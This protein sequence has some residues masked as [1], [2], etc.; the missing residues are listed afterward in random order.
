MEDDG[1]I[2]VVTGLIAIMTLG[3]IGQ[4][5]YIGVQDCANGKLHETIA[6]QDS[7]IMK[8]DSIIMQQ[9]EEIGVLTIQTDGIGND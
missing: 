1:L 7:V 4:G 5:V 9:Y 3:L 8:Q 6:M 2:S